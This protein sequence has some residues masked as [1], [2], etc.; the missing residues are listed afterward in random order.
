MKALSRSHEARACLWHNGLQFP[1]E[2]RDGHDR[3]KQRK[4]GQKLLMRNDSK[5][6]NMERMKAKQKKMHHTQ[7]RHKGAGMSVVITENGALR[8]DV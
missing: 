2:G 8:G 4:A 7:S 3:W 5:M 6:Q 1:R